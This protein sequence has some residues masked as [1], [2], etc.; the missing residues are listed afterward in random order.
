MPLSCRRGRIVVTVGRARP[1]PRLSCPPPGRPGAAAAPRA[2][3]TLASRSPA[4]RAARVPGGAAGGPGPPAWG[5]TGRAPRD[6][7]G[8]R[9]SGGRG[10][11]GRGSGG[12]GAGR[13]EAGQFVGG[14]SQRPGGDILG[15]VLR[16]AGA[17]DG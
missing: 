5:L 14:E 4:G 7:S 6:G 2:A 11:G 3:L 17:G 8:G 12:R 10:S 16:V 9:G 1:P 15:Q 13:V